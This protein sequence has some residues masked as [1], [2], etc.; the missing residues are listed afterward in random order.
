MGLISFIEDAGERLLGAGTAIKAQPHGTEAQNVDQLNAAAGEA[1]TRYIA[2][3]NLKAQDLRVVYIGASKTVTVS[4][5][6]PDLSTKEKIVLCCGNVHSVAKVNDQLTLAQAA[7]PSFPPSTTYDVKPGDTLSKIAK[8]VYG[9]A[10]DYQKIF[11][12][13][14]P[15][16]RDPDKIYP[17]Q[18]L[19]IPPK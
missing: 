19:R 2:A 17:G 14:K 5:I 11:E 1:I 9:D 4:G 7:S 6:A 18:Q 13:N 3:Q 12:A 8:A 15:M 16:L 10:N